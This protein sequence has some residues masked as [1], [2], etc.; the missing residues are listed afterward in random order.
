MRNRKT[1]ALFCVWLM[2][3]TGCGAAHDLPGRGVLILNPL[4]MKT[5]LSDPCTDS[6]A[7]FSIRSVGR[8]QNRP[9]GHP[10]GAAASFFPP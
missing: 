8:K 10:E 6:G 7:D 9:Q 4:N 5:P 2:L 1:I 3:L